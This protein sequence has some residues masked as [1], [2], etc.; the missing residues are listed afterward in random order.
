MV[1][2]GEVVDF[3]GKANVRFGSKADIQYLIVEAIQGSV[4]ERLLSAKSGHS[5]VLSKQFVIEPDGGK[6]QL[7]S[8]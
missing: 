4:P 1:E 2:S 6:T 7:C 5:V 3:R 8:F